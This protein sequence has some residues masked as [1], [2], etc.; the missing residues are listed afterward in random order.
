MFWDILD[1][2]VEGSEVVI[3]RPRGSAHPRY[4]EYI[5][6]LDYG[7]ISSTTSDDGAEIDVWIGSGSRKISGALITFDPVKKDVE[8]KLLVGCNT[9]EVQKCLA[10]SS[11]GGMVSCFVKRDK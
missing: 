8:T 9:E 5:Y 1:K 6:P 10:S 11:R 3:E 7:Y 4:P 2:L